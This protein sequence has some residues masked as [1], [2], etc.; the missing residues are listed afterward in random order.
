MVN[1]PWQWCTNMGISPK[2]DIFT[3][4]KQKIHV[5]NKKVN[6][7]EKGRMTDDQSGIGNAKT[8]GMEW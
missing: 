6:C 2:Y 3:M 5:Y 4:D 8:Q 7:V 1:I